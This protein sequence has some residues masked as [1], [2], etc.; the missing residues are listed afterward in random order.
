V[1]GGLGFLFSRGDSIAGSRDGVPSHEVLGENLAALELR[2]GL[3]WAEDEAA[4]GLKKIDDAID[5]RPFGADNGEIGVDLIGQGQQVVRFGGRGTD[6]GG[7]QRA[8]G[9]TGRDNHFPDGG[10][11][12][13][14]PGNG[15]L[16]PAA[17]NNKDFH[18]TVSFAGDSLGYL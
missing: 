2:R 6:A 12:V 13:E 10:A 7:Y 8:A 16:T 15:V 3:S 14:P 1:E 18:G 5:E 17:A 11:A 9:I 4:I